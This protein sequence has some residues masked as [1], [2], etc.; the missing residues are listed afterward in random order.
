MGFH[1]VNPG[2]AGLLDVLG[3]T[4]VATT[5]RSRTGYGVLQPKDK[6]GVKL[7][8]VLQELW[9]RF[10]IYL[11]TSKEVPT[12]KAFEAKVYYNG[13][14]AHFYA[15]DSTIQFFVESY[16]SG[17]GLSP[18]ST[19]VNKSNMEGLKAECYLFAGKVNSVYMHAKRGTGNATDGAFELWFNG[20][21]FINGAI[22]CNSWSDSYVT[23]M[24]NSELLLISDIIISDT[25]FDKRTQ[26]VQAP[27]AGIESGKMTQMGDGSY[28]ATEA[29][30]TLL[31]HLDMEALAASYGGSSRVTGVAVIGNPAY[32]MES[33]GGTLTG[34]QSLSGT[35]TEYA[36]QP[37]QSDAAGAICDYHPLDGTV[38]G[39]SGLAVGWKTGV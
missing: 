3:A 37:L 13:F 10:D 1:Y 21:P 7:G 8:A 18:K 32:Q 35:L 27:V 5:G 24:S 17:I 6:C 30:Q 29:G 14:G 22:K 20:T 11:P 23:V 25:A 31:Q 19:T 34:I 38:D 16:S 12:N 4:T 28:I 36:T 33:G 26:L 39:L 9:I 15:Y 2:F